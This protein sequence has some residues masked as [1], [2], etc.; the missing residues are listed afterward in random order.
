MFVILYSRARELVG[1]WAI[2]DRYALGHLSIRQIKRARSIPWRLYSNS[3]TEVVVS[4]AHLSAERKVPE[5]QELSRVTKQP[6][7]G[8]EY[9]P[10][11]DP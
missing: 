3:T 9:P 7:A 6:M 2:F 5:L 1:A 4:T 8:I 11:L 10:G